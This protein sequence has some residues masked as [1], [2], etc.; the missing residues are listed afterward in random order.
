MDVLYNYLMKKKVLF[1]ITKSNWGGAQR[2][3]Y[4]L[5]TTLPADTFDVVVALGGVGGADAVAGT[6]ETKLNAV[7][8]RTI[9]VPSFMRDVSVLKDAYVVRE[10]IGIFRRERPDIVHLNSS[11]AGGLGALAARLAGIDTII[12]TSHGLAWDENRNIFAKV[13]IYIFSRITFLLCTAVIVIST[14]NY[15]RARACILCRKKIHLIHNVLPSLQFESREEAR[16]SLALKVG[17]TKDNADIWIG[18]IAELTRNKALPSLVE[19]AAHLLRQEKAFHFFIIG[20]GEEEQNLRQQIKNAHLEDRVHLLGF[21][22]DAY[23]YDKAFD[24]FALISVKEGLPTV[25]LEA[26]HAGSTVVASR[27]SGT[28]DII[29][30]NKTGLLTEPK[31]AQ[32]ISNKITVLINDPQKRIHLG[33]ALEQKVMS[34]FSLEK[35]VHETTTLYL[36]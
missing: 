24:I 22:E 31:N 16:A 19:A 26:G 20:S 14:D 30:D 17:L 7:G 33:H 18:T 4:N 2:Y 35:M 12:F 11:K 36:S 15:R 34:E 29:E 6:L 1:V 10:L 13:A 27:I 9:F 8:I 28:T 23:R 5:A 21:I 32:D 25:L 3:V